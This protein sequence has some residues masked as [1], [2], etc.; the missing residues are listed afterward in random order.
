[1]ETLKDFAGK[2]M[3]EQIMLLEEIKESGRREAV[4]ALVALYAEPLADQA[5]DEMVY[6]TLFDLLAAD[7]EQTIAALGHQSPRVRLLAVRR[8]GESGFRGALPV[9]LEILPAAESEVLAETIRALARFRDPAVVDA[10]LPFLR[11]PDY[12]V[13]AWAMRA[14]AGFPEPRVGQ[15]LK[16]LITTDPG[17]SQGECDLRLALAVETLAAFRDEETAGFLAGQIH[18]SCPAFRKE[19][20]GALAAMGEGA[21]PALEKTLA[22]GDKDEKIMAANVLGLG[23]HKKGAD[24]L[25]EQLHRPGLDPNLRFAIYEALGRIPSMRSVVGLSDGLA[26]EDEMVLLAVAT[27]MDHLCNPGI[28]KALGQVLARKDD[29]SRRVVK[30]IVA[31]RAGRLLAALYPEHGDALVGQ[32]AALADPEA[33]AV[34]RG[35]LEKMEGERPAADLARLTGGKTEVA[36]RRLLAADD[37]K[38]MLFF[39][40]G[41]AAE[42]KVE[43]L[44]AADGKEALERLRGGAQ[45]DLLITDM[46]MPN[47]DGVELAREVRRL[48]HGAALP[49]LMATT[50]SERSQVDLALAAG[51]NDF[52]SKPFTSEQLRAKIE[53]V[54][55]KG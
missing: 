47:M 50:E 9:L 12:A 44:T 16:E 45:V 36:G 48:P 11:H 21:L 13:C 3:I 20:V 17:L 43:L 31:A 26:E 39:Y 8:A 7:E 38:A 55:A 28:V 51:V 6:H 10:L 4:P 23:G 24:V 46:N 27:A 22:A 25:V 33:A 18:H 29:Q 41:V 1:M 19:V 14:L 40:K 52:I 37:S 2:D 5:V 34:F 15:A 30:A 54:F 35:E 53:A 42:L 32:A 49:I